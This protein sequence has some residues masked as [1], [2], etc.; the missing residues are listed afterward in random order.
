[1]NR[2]HPELIF[3]NTLHVPLNHTYTKIDAHNYP[4]PLYPICKTDTHTTPLQLQ[5]HTHSVVTPGFV[6]ELRGGG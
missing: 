3:L 5:T 1:M 6:D 2:F 4:S